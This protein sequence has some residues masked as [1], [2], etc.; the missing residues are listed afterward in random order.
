VISFAICLW[1][2]NSVLKLKCCLDIRA[3][4]DDAFLV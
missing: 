2:L 3:C 1:A 4:L